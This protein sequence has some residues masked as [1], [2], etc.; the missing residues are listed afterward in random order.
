MEVVLYNFTKSENSTAI[1]SGGT[2][3]N[4]IL[5]TPTSVLNP[6]IVV[7]A[8]VLNVTYGYIPDFGRY[9]FVSDIVSVN[10][11]TWELHL[12]V[13]V[14]ATYKSEIL[15]TEAYIARATYGNTNIP[16]NLIVGMSQYNITDVD[17]GAG[18]SGQP[19]FI[20]SVID[21]VNGGQVRE[22]RQCII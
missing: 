15:S 18:I 20:L 5:K 3:Y 10:N 11:S 9:Y 12:H 1:P 8:N 6:V 21:C 19:G 2:S 22:Q 16:D 14:L 17:S 13:D 7:E 4:C